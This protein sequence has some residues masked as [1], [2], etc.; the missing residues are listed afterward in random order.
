MVTY[1]L[2]TIKT[3]MQSTLKRD[4]GELV[5]NRFWRERSFRLGFMISVLR[6]VIIDGTNFAVFENCRQFLVSS[7]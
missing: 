5:R 6:S 1:P 3:N 4:A 2:D 7:V